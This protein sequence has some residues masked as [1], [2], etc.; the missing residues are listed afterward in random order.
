MHYL[1]ANIFRILVMLVAVCFI[2]YGYCK[3]DALIMVVSAI[4]PIL[5]WF[6]DTYLNTK[7]GIE[8]SEKLSEAEE[9][10]TKTERELSEAKKKIAELE[11]CVTWKEI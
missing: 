6:I 11:D 7:R 1:K 10:V 3:E 5:V 4:L 9:K 8:M 2:A